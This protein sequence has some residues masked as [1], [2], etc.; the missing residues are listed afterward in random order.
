M[1][2]IVL[3]CLAIAIPLGAAQAENWKNKITKPE[4]S[5]THSGAIRCFS[6]EKN[7]WCLSKRKTATPGEACQCGAASGVLKYQGQINQG[8]GSCG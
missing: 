4:T 8:V 5:V 2:K 6:S 1:K 7:C 3:A